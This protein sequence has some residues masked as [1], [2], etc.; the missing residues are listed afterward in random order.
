MLN[1]L[2]TLVLVDKSLS[3][4]L[5][6]LGPLRVQKRLINGFLEES[7]LTQF[8]GSCWIGEGFNSSKPSLHLDLH[9]GGANF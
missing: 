3:E 2:I 5:M 9:G 4:V 7:Y 6:L 1:L 8:K